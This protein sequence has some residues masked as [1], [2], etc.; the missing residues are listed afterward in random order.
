[1]SMAYDN[2]RLYEMALQLRDLERDLELADQIQRG[3][4]PTS[5]PQIS[6]YRFFDFYRPASYV[7]G[8]FYNYVSLPDGRLGVVVA[9]VVV[10]GLAAAMLTAK[11]AAELRYQL[12]TAKQAGEAITRL[13]RSLAETIGESRFITLVAIMLDPASGNMTLV[14]AGH[15]PPILFQ[16]GGQS[17]E[18]GMQESGFPL[19][20][21]DDTVYE[22]CSVRLPLGGL[23]MV[24]TDGIKEAMNAENEVYGLARLRGL[25]QR[26]SGDPLQIGPIIVDDVRRF[27][28]DHPPPD[29]MCLV[30]FCRE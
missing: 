18:I 25:V 20:V 22:E 26:A 29:D 8:D 15:P 24:Y 4:L 19:G 2:A 14:N 12:M 10:H 6:G 3:F 5:L 27:L 30:C 21:A 11:F 17:V 28:G 23:V 16:P 9:D 7:G 1:M 13:N